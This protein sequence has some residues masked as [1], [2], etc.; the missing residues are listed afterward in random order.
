[1]WE[2][3]LKGA[4]E[5]VFNE[6]V[7]K[8]FAWLMVAVAVLLSLGLWVGR[9]NVE[10][11]YN[12]VTLSVNYTDL[13][14]LANANGLSNE[15]MG[16]LLR[17]RGISSILF[18]EISLGDLDREGKVDLV[19]G[20]NLKQ[21]PFYNQVNEK[22]TISDGMLYVCI[23]SDVYQEQVVSHLQSKLPGVMY[24]KGEVEVVAVPITIPSSNSELESNF[25]TVS[26]L[27]VGYNQAGIAQVAEMG[28]GVIPQVRTWAEP[29]AMSLHFMVDELKGIPNLHHIL[30]NDKELPGYPDD[31]RTLAYLLNADGAPLAPVGTIEFSDQK[32]LN[33]LGVLLDKD[34]IR[35]H[36]IANNEMSKYTVD[37]ALD[38]W[39]LAVEERNM[40]SLLVRFFDIDTPGLSLEKNMDYLDQLSQGLVEAGYD[41]GGMYEK[42]ESFGGNTLVLLVVGLGVGAGLMLILLYMGLPKLSVVGFVGAAV[43][44]IGLYFLAPTMARKLMALAS[45]IIFPILSC[46]LMMKA[47]RRSILQS[48]AGILLMCA[49]SWI[50]AI[51]MVAIL[52]DVLFMLKLDQFIGVKIAHVIPVLAVPL[53][54]YIWNDREPMA[55]VKEILDKAITYKWGLLAGVIVV[56]GVIYI[57]R[58]GNATAE[59][60]AAE[61]LMRRILNDVMG[62]RPRSKEFLIGYPCAM[63]LF[64]YGA[65]KQ[66]WVLMIPA[67]IGQVSLVNTYAH[68]H[69]ALGASLMRSF[70]G[71]L[72]GL[73]I[74]VLAIVGVNLLIKIW[75]KLGKIPP[76]AGDLT[77]ELLKR[78][79]KV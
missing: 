50:G 45:V 49:L 14:S 65:T 7:L 44:W 25:R 19:Y 11:A 23:L 78:G 35:L 28:F 26:E 56:A 68:I 39:M 37:E 57:S 9:M 61:E 54:L 66:N 64:Y 4:C 47:G 33:E 70:N 60:S 2:D 38:R 59:L 10:R 12:Q 74:G 32:G 52:G 43:C 55:R 29:T 72:L 13:V 34:V 22:I 20:E 71:L 58:T 18:K 5:G 77:P 41:I 62:V 31:I 46:I 21:A 51:L 42:P 6:R 16:D 73:I 69:T 53:I 75:Q 24:Y 30:F 8:R 3:N 36:T 17:E 15:A 79:K 48:I 76:R 63:L 27:G 67:V 1:M 40:R